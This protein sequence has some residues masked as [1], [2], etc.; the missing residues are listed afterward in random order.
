[1]D[2]SPAIG[3]TGLSRAL[4]LGLMVAAP[5]ALISLLARFAT[6]GRLP[7]GYSPSFPNAVT[8]TVYFATAVNLG[9]LCVFVAL[10]G[11]MAAGWLLGWD[12]GQ[13]IRA[14]IGLVLLVA[15]FGLVR[16]SI[17]NVALIAMRKRNGGNLVGS[18]DI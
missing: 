12:I 10:L 13:L 18:E 2:T 17:V 3:S 11:G 1:M 14:I 8:A 15:L 5:V 4:I 16:D 9:L 7:K 6:I